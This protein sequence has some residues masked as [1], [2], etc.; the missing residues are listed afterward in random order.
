MTNAGD[1]YR[2]S[3]KPHSIGFSSLF[4]SNYGNGPRFLKAGSRLRFFYLHS[5]VFSNTKAAYVF[6][7]S[8][9]SVTIRNFLTVQAEY[10]NN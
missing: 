4:L 10:L 2:I 3:V 8:A 9:L 1:A 7:T 6:F 5:Y